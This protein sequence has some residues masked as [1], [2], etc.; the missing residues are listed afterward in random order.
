MPSNYQDISNKHREQYGTDVGRYGGPLLV[1]R[2]DDRTHFIYELLQNAEDALKR[3][4]TAWEGSRGVHFELANGQLTVSHS[5]HP[6]TRSDVESV[7][8]IALSTKGDEA[9]GK[10][11]IGFKSVYTFSNRPEIHSGD[12]DFAIRDFVHPLAL[13][14]LDREDEETKIVLPLNVNEDNAT[15]EILRGLRGLGPNALLFLRHITEVSWD[16]SGGDAGLY[17]RGQ[18]VVLGN[19]VSHV[20]V[21]GK[22]AAGNEIDQDWLVFTRDVGKGAVEIAFSLQTDKDGGTLVQPLATSP[23]VVFFP[24]VFPTNLGFLLQGPFLTT[25]S[26][27]NI[28]RGSTWNTKLIEET[29]VLLVDALQWLR[30]QGR[31]DIPTIRCLP[32]DATKFPDGG[33]FSPLYHATKT[34]FE[35]LALLPTEAGTYVKA[36]QAKLARTTDLRQLISND[37]LTGLFGGEDWHWLAGD[38]TANRTPEVRNY[39][40][41]VLDIEEVTPEKVA[42]RLSKSFLESQPD[43]WIVRLYEFLTT[44][45]A[46]VRQ[47]L[48]LTPYVRLE[49]GTHV[50]ATADVFLPTESASG[51]PTVRAAVC[52][53]EA[54][55][56]FLKDLGITYPDP[57][58]DV[59]RNILPKYNDD[60][61]DIEESAYAADMARILAAYATDSTSKR[62]RLIDALKE[63][64]FVWCVD[65][66]SGER[67]RSKPSECYT[68]SDRLEKL[69]AGIEGIFLVDSSQECLRGDQARTLL[70]ACGVSRFLRPQQLYNELGFVRRQQL[71]STATQPRSSG[72]ND[73]DEDWALPDLQPLLELLPRLPR[74]A[75]IERAALLWESI[76]DV[77]VL[78]SRTYFDGVYSWTMHGAHRVQFPASFVAM[79][80]ETPWVPDKYGELSPPKL[81]VFEELGWKDSPFVLSKIAF[82]PRAI[83]QLAQEAGID[84]DALDFIRKHGISL[85]DL[86]D[87]L[88]LGEPLTPLDASEEPDG[89]PIDNGD[90]EPVDDVYGAAGD[91]Y[92]DDMP[93]I[94]PGSVDPD[95]TDDAARRGGQAGA[96]RERAPAGSGTAG[97]PGGA[98][99]GNRSPG[100]PLTPGAPRAGAQGG[101][102]TFVSYVGAHEDEEDDP[103]GLTQAERMRVE[104]EAIRYILSRE[105]ALHRTTVGNPGFDLFE[106]D[107]TGRVLRWVEVKSMTGTLDGRP[108]TMSSC[109]LEFAMTKGAAY[110]L[111]IVESTLD[112]TQRTLRR[113]QNPAGQAKYFTFDRGWRAVST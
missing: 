1:E 100:H 108:A 24:T 28:T 105:P 64:Y 37:Q 111:Y 99:R 60:D 45:P 91:L 89:A 71:R 85:S 14:W 78:G 68:A 55:L 59:I 44:Q 21:I 72:Q 35:T 30:D 15:P 3:R 58:D 112:D 107:P 102:R 7:C 11:G 18:P 53:S 51:F 103:D 32:I 113:I 110:W 25:P 79:L 96:V 52:Q 76:A 74:E 36:G 46:A 88:G 5:G 90:E 19:G 61:C 109:Q 81:V 26:R 92:G 94:P 73:R 16:I 31:L 93:D 49:D 87:K 70:V 95:A 69:F 43:E 17:M 23:L 6:F 86:K 84:P 38:I 42:S 12:E 2:Y 47:S 48:A 22:T 63:T 13:P 65:C 56:K 40:T 106:T 67:F 9:I 20:S 8:S 62:V 77:E 34:A 82:K 33:M 41:N 27:D 57:V 83:D 4:G 97:N 10:F 104:E 29:S 75:Q 39:L 50:L 54:S 101:E 80:N 66:G 98:G